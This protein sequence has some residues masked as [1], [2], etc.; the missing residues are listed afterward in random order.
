[1]YYVVV[2]IGCSECGEAS[3]IVGIFSSKEK[4]IDAREYYVKDN[5]L[6]HNDDHELLIY[7]IDEL[8]KIYNN[9]YEHL[10]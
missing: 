7:K 1:M 5:R 4:A 8:D 9:S 3:N 6:E 2:D 10:I